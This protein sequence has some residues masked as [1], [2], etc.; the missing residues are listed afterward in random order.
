MNTGDTITVGSWLAYVWFNCCR[1]CAV[2][3]SRSRSGLS[4]LLSAQG[5]VFL[6]IP[7]GKHTAGLS[8][9]VLLLNTTDTLLENGR[10]LGGRG[11]GFGVGTGLDRADNGCGISLGGKKQVSRRS[12]FAI[13]EKLETGKTAQKSFWHE[14]PDGVAIQ[15]GPQSNFMMKRALLRR[16]RWL[17]RSSRGG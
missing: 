3:Y 7:D 12:S 4:R 15:L 17:A 13:S 5:F 1:C 8:E 9:V 14:C 10:D 11:L 6:H 16:I 2:A